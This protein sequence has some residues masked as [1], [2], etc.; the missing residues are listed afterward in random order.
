MGRVLL[1]ED[2]LIFAETVTDLLSLTL[3]CTVD[4]CIR[5]GDALNHLKSNQYDLILLDWQLP[6]ISGINLLKQIRQTYPSARVIMM[7]GMSDPAALEAAL[8]E[9]AEDVLKKPFAAPQLIER[10]RLV[11]GS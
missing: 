5:G 8:D 3:N 10:A 2:D 1:V 11:L 7:T 9:G 4:S 6:D